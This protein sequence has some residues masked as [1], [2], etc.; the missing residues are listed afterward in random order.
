M[1]GE[2][3]QKP[4]EAGQ[5][6]GPVSY[7]QVYELNDQKLIDTSGA[8]GMIKRS[9]GMV[10]TGFLIAPDILITNQHMISSQKWAKDTKVLF[11]Y[12]RDKP[13]HVLDADVFE[14]DPDFYYSSPK[15]KLDYALLKLKRKSGKKAGDKW[16][17]LKLEP[18]DISSG[19]FVTIIEHPKGKPKVVAMKGNEVV[20]V[21]KIHV[22]YKTDSDHGSSGSPVIN[23]KG[24]VV[25]LHHYAVGIPQDGGGMIF[26][27][28]GI[29][30]GPI[31]EHLKEGG[32]KFNNGVLSGPEGGH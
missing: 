6:F 20:S 14:C 30:I 25:A 31:I 17:Y 8:V 22:E 13:G 2:M 9:D 27:N 15:E 26:S 21:N 19:D 24:Q 5:G 28:E 4:K 3:N 12:Q 11:N 7:I 10:G 1:S 16:A 32:F 29:R 23:D 18:T